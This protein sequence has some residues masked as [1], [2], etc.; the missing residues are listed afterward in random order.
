MTEADR[1]AENANVPHALAELVVMLAEKYGRTIK[2]LRGECRDRDLVQ[3]RKR[4]AREG[5]HRRYSFPQIGRALNRDHSTIISHV[6]GR[7]G[8]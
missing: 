1:L 6:N 8:R 3:I 7:R 2:Q 4:I 5:R